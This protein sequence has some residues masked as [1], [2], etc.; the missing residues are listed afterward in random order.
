MII[1]LLCFVIVV[2]TASVSHA[3]FI[4]TGDFRNGTGQLLI[5]DSVTFS[6]TAGTDSRIAGS[7]DFSVILDNIVT[8]D[9]SLDALTSSPRL[10]FNRNG[11]PLSLS[12]HTV[13]RDNFPIVYGALTPG[14]AQI[15]GGAAT[16]LAAN[17]TLTLLAGAYA[18][19]ASSSGFNPQYNGLTFAGDAFIIDV[20]G[21]RLSANV[22]VGS[23]V[24][25]P[26]AFTLLGIAALG[27]IAVRF[28]GARSG[29]RKKVSGMA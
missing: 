17:D 5:T 9:G 18:F 19:P 27:A 11:T 14:D 6:L 15:L 20:D 25:E 23:V 2:A 10:A 1:R 29:R 7:G 3:A 8:F 16:P 12:S 21:N 4:F 26:G 24:P 22:N 13:F 28:R